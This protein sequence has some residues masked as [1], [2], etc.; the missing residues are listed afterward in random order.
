MKLLALFDFSFEDL[1]RI[2]WHSDSEARVFLHWFTALSESNGL[3]C[4]LN[5]ASIFS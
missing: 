4:S 2:K 5:R 1:M 3:D